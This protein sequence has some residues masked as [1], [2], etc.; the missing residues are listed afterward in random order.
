MKVKAG[1]T[2]TPIVTSAAVSGT[3]PP[4]TNIGRYARRHRDRIS[5]YAPAHPLFDLLFAHQDRRHSCGKQ[6]QQKNGDQIADH[7]Q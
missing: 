4:F 5:P 7:A 1:P 3:S 2:P 6:A